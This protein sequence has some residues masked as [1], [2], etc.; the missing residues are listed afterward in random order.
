M[1]LAG[2][3]RAD[4]YA[5]L[6]P[7]RQLDYHH[8]PALQVAG[9]RWV[10]N[11]VSTSGIA[12]LNRHDDRWFEVPRSLPHVRLVTQVQATRQPDIDIGNIRLDTTALSEVPIA[13]PT[14]KPGSAVLKTERP[15]QLEIEV[16]CPARQLLVVAEG[17]HAGWRAE[18]DGSSQQVYRLNGDFMGCL[19]EEGKHR[20]VLSFQPASLDRGRLASYIGLSVISLCFLGFSPR[21]NSRKIEGVFTV[22]ENYKSRRP[23]AEAALLSVVLPVYNEA[24][25]LPILTARIANALG[26]CSVAY[27]LVFVDDGSSDQSSRILDQLAGSSDKI[28]V[29]HLSR[30]FGHQAAVQ[31]GLANARGDAVVLM[32]SDMQDS[33]EAIP[34]F[35]AQWR[36]GYDVVYAIRTQRKENLLKRSLFAAFHRLMSAVASTPIPAEAGIFGLIDRRVAQQIVAL[37]E[38]DR[39]FPG[40]RSWV[41][42]RQTGIEVERNARYDDRPRVSLAGLVRLAK[43]AMFSF[44]SFPLTVFHL[45]GLAA[46]LVFVGL[47]GFSVFCRLFT[48]QAIPGW[49]S[50]ILTGSFFGALNAFGISMLGE[51]VIRIYD[52]V[53]GRPPYVVDRMVNFTASL[54]DDDTAGDAPYVAL[55]NEATLLL[56]EGT[57]RENR[58]N[59]DYEPIEQCE[60]YVTPQWI[61]SY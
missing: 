10:Q 14:S 34:R 15:G 3:R 28:R 30:N 59:D 32:D 50:H 12:G 2:W 8:L 20:V 52:Q 1:T 55:M 25:V 4:G 17:Y 24:E 26:S 61:E 13:L 43:T 58:Q 47:S 6:E 7:R 37:G 19:V 21:T 42:F 49:T 57:I 36:A 27:E 29:I 51:Y 22:N 18:I 23:S 46:A 48:N 9:V 44:S 31:A 5:G 16:D 41:G 11:D 60:Q 35:L 38:S 40:L 56:A 45:I 33:P 39:Y 54:P 53:R